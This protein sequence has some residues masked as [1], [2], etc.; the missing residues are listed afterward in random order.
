MPKKSKEYIQITKDALRGKLAGAS[1][2]YFGGTMLQLLLTWVLMLA[3]FVPLVFFAVKSS[4]AL[5]ATLTIGETLSILLPLVIGF[6]ILFAISGCLQLGTNNFMLK[7][8]QGEKAGIRDMFIGFKHPLRTVGNFLLLVGRLLLIGI[9]GAIAIALLQIPLMFVPALASRLMSIL[10]A[11][12]LYVL[13][14]AIALRFAFI[15]LMQLLHPEMK[16]REW[17]N[18]SK[19]VMKNNR[20]NLIKLNLSVWYLYLPVVA[21]SAF[22]SYM[23]SK[24]V[25]LSSPSILLLVITILYWV[26]CIPMGLY[27]GVLNTAFGCDLDAQL[28]PP[29]TIEEDIA[30]LAETI[31]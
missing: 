6:P 8:L 11:V 12:C 4:K 23:S 9:I 28:D 3:I 25:S 1:V 2:R 19:S 31:E 24:F 10:L 17:H 22:N 20:W 18:R 26:Y 16:I 21:Y 7:M 5:N 14:I 15:F 29:T 27:V 13:L 30:A